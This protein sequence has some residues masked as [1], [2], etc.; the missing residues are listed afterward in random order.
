[1]VDTVS[2]SKKDYRIYKKERLDRGFLVLC[3]YTLAAARQ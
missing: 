1:M 3:R 2:R